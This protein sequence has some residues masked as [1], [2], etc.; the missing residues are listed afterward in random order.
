MPHPTCRVREGRS[1]RLE[2]AQVG[3][4]PGRCRVHSRPHRR[5]H[6]AHLWCHALQVHLTQ[7]IPAQC[8]TAFAEYI[9]LLHCSMV[10]PRLVTLST[11]SR[12]P[13]ITGPIPVSLMAVAIMLP[14]G[15]RMGTHSGNSSCAQRQH[16]SATQLETRLSRMP[17]RCG[18][19]I[20]SCCT[21]S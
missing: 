8:W 7:C 18:N 13:S 21:E 12:A 4:S 3:C 14:S 11:C 9:V 20:G 16:V 6:P 15:D 10:H 2:Q 5:T 17:S 1:L 19:M